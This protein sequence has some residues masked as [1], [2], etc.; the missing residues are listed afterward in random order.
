MMLVLTATVLYLA[1]VAVSGLL[2][3]NSSMEAWFASRADAIVHLLAPWTPPSNRTGPVPVRS[4][5]VA[6]YVV[7]HLRNFRESAP[8]WNDRL[9]HDKRNSHYAFDIYV[10]T[11]LVG[12]EAEKAHMRAEVLRVYSAP[13]QGR[14]VRAIIDTGDLAAEAARGVWPES[15]FHG[16]TCLRPTSYMFVRLKYCEHARAMAERAHGVH[17]DLAMYLRPDVIPDRAMKLDLFNRP[18]T[19]YF[20]LGTVVR[21]AHGTAPSP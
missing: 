1:L 21:P 8:F 13:A 19:L 3:L 18:S 10:C 11:S 4:K 7:G 12:S 15:L 2:V 14:V 17:Y 16:T 9:F 20:L 5:R 6:L